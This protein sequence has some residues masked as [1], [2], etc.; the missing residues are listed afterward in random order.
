[1]VFFVDC[2]IWD[3]PNTMC[4]AHSSAEVLVISY[5]QRLAKETCQG[6]LGTYFKQTKKE[7]APERV[8]FTSWKAFWY[9]ELESLDGGP[10]RF[11]RNIVSWFMSTQ[12][13]DGTSS[14]SS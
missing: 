13:P 1:L 7:C 4:F 8:F 3:V 5:I 11:Q 6:S 10:I 14:A 9:L 2:K 12:W